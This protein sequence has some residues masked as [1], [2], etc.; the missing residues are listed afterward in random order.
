MAGSEDA[1]GAR[2]RRVCPPLPLKAWHGL[3]SDNGRYFQET[4]L[5]SSEKI[6][7]EGRTTFTRECS[8]RV[9]RWLLCG[10]L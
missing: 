5:V 2:V 8:F 7:G 9:Q 3:H 1:R 6:E 4:P 10:R